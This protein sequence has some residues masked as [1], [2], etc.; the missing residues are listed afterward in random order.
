[1]FVTIGGFSS[2]CF[3]S[4]TGGFASAFFTS[5]GPAT[6]ATSAGFA[7]TTGS[8]F[9]GVHDTS[10]RTSEEV[11]QRARPGII[12]PSYP[13]P[14]RTNRLMLRIPASMRARAAVFAECTRISGGTNPRVTTASS[15]H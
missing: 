6:S 8:T 15:I 5:T 4:T 2:A 12:D 14:A 3:T 10:E 9:V 13:R 1:V 11:K 7:S